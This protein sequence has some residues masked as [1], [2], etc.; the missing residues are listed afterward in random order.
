MTIP[1]ICCWTISRPAKK[2]NEKTG[3]DSA[4]KTRT[5]LVTQSK[6]FG[7]LNEGKATTFVNASL[8]AQN[9]VPRFSEPAVAR[10]SVN[11]DPLPTRSRQAKLFH[12]VCRTAY[13]AFGPFRHPVK[14]A[15]IH[16]PFR[17]QFQDYGIGYAAKYTESSR[18][19]VLCRA[20]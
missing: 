16:W 14:P 19:R 6:M 9:L 4:E 10:A 7:V 17:F 11:P 1:A 12:R 5:R 18:Y 13:C 8:L 3:L 15:G 20:S 2:L